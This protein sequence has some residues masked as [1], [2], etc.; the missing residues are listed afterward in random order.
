MRFDYGPGNAALTPTVGLSRGDG[1]ALLAGYDGATSLDGA[2]SIEFSLV[3]S[4]VD[5]GAYEF[6]GSTLDTTPPTVESTVIRR[7]TSEAPLSQVD[8]SF[9]EPVDPIDALAPANYEM[10]EAGAD[11]LFGSSDD[12]V[13][14]LI[15]S[16][17]PGSTRVVLDIVVPGGGPL[18]EGKFQF[19]ISGNTSIHD[20]A[21]FTPK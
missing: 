5:I 3:P 2:N 17:S 1:T 14:G 19:T 8:V 18:P 6:E 9:S 21:G 13:Y 20:L 16:Y 10:R 4:F 15:P 11:G 12:T 7:G